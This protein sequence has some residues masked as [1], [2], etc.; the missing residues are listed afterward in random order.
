M[1]L[2]RRRRIL[3]GR[4]MLLLLSALFFAGIGAVVTLRLPATY[5]VDTALLV[6]RSA[7][8]SAPGYDDLLAA[9]LLAQT[10]AEL[11][12]TRPILAA[13]T[14]HLK[15]SETPEQLADEITAQVSGLNPI[16]RITVRGP[17]PA[18]AARVADEIARQLIAWRSSG[19]AAPG[20]LPE[21]NRTLTTVDSEIERAQA[22]V[23]S[24]LRV[25][26][27]RLA[28]LLAT[29]ASLLQLITD[30]PA[31]TL[32]VIEPAQTPSEPARRGLLL[33]ATAA[34]LLGLLLM[35]G[36]IALTADD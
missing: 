13:V 34:A 8:G 12:S 28:S 10:Y 3:V 4:A 15:L 32:A 36:A 29:R 1:G 18:G 30:T 11:A 24:N 16:V 7:V 25:A 20:L 33:N 19:P 31:N 35:A 9:Q 2:R 14:D 26:L 23:K 21:L 6:S 27:D 5:E 22:E 17:D